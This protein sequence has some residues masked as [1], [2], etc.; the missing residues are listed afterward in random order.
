MSTS[1]LISSRSFYDTAEAAVSFAKKVTLIE[2]APKTALFGMGLDS[3]FAVAIKTFQEMSLWEALIHLLNKRAF[4]KIEHEGQPLLIKISD[5]VSRLYVKKEK[6]LEAVQQGTLVQFMTTHALQMQKVYFKYDEIVKQYEARYTDLTDNKE[7]ILKTI[8]KALETNQPLVRLAGKKHLEVGILGK[9]IGKGSFGRVSR[10]TTYTYNKNRRKFTKRQEALKCARQQFKNLG[11]RDAKR[12]EMQEHA[13]GDIENERKQLEKFP[14]RVWGIQ[15]A[16]REA[17]EITIETPEIKQ[18]VGYIDFEYDQN[19]A[20][21]ID[22]IHQDPAA[23]TTLFSNCLQE[24]HQIL[25]GLCYLNQRGLLHG[26]I[27]AENVLRDEKFAHIADMGGVCDAKETWS[28]EKLSG[29][30]RSASPAYSVKEDLLKACEIVEKA[31][32]LDQ[33]KEEDRR[34]YQRLRREIIELEQK[35]AIFSGACVLYRRLTGHLPFEKFD[36]YGFPVLSSY[37]E[38]AR[39]DIPPEFNSVLKQMLSADYK[40]R[41]AHVFRIYEE[42]LAQRFPQQLTEIRKQKEAFEKS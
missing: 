39:A 16:P 18:K 17:G 27:K 8:K 4:V 6:V 30:T 31:K 35:R 28:V 25:H 10:V 21:Y 19:Y 5:I 40:K 9:F 36:H 32:K 12:K 38:L 33:T 29:V 42:I 7:V 23:K 26:D 24:F 15:I 34:M 13:K 1:H 3:R 20:I 2:R 14:N 22:S 11:R 41:P 37:Q